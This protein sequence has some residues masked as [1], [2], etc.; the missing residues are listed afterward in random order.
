MEMEK[1]VAMP[2]QEIN[3]ESNDN[4]GK[5][6]FHKLKLINLSSPK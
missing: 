6:D 3:Q 1:Q 2:L 5:F 4:K